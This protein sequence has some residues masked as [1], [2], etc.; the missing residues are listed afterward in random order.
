MNQAL[1]DLVEQRVAEPWS[2]WAAKHPHLAAAI[3][4]ER[5]IEGAVQQ[6][7]SDPEYRR[8]LAAAEIDEQRLRDAARLFS[9][10]ERIAQPTLPW[11]VR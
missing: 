8:A 7:E 2:Q 4:R 3:D 9:L 6:I 10:V 11:L 1:R 5:L